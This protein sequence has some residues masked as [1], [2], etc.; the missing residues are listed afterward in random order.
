VARRPKR[1]PICFAAHL[2]SERGEVLEKAAGHRSEARSSA[3]PNRATS[4]SAAPMTPL[5]FGQNL[6]WKAKAPE[7]RSPPRAKRAE[8][9]G[10]RAAYT[11]LSQDD[12][13]MVIG[14]GLGGRS[15][16]T[17]PSWHEWK[18]C[19]MRACEIAIDAWLDILACAFSFLRTQKV[20]FRTRSL[21]W[22]ILLFWYKN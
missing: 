2:D 17:L 15:Q 1:R 21:P 7:G 3:A 11:T 14:I 12:Q 13:E 5:Q 20:A 10:S 19:P 8:G 18:T 9:K 6:K 22:N 4:G 16:R